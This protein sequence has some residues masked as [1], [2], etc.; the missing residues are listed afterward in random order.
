V[1]QIRLLNGPGAVGAKFQ[2]AAEKRILCERVWAAPH[3]QLKTITLDTGTHAA[4][5]ALKAWL[6]PETAS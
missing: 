2:A 1:V 4:K 6:K 5:A 3:V